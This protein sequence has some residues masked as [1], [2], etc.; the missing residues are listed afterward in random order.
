MCISGREGLG[1][2]DEPAGGQRG[3]DE[4]K[5]GDRELRQ[6]DIGLGWVPGKRCL[7]G[8]LSPA[9]MFW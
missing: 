8:A 9:T 6:V 5:D 3:Q 4:G 2:A 1:E 7:N